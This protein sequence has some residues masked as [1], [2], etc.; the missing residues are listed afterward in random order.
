MIDFRLPN[1]DDID[2]SADS[3]LRVAGSNPLFT[4]GRIPGARVYRFRA[5]RTKKNQQNFG[6]AE[7]LN[8][9]EKTL[10]IEDVDLYI[11]KV[12]WKRGVLRVNEAGSEGYELSFHMDAGDI[13]QKLSGRLM[14]SLGLGSDPRDLLT[15]STYPTMNYVMFPVKNDVFYSENANYGGTVNAYASGAYLANDSTNKTKYSLTPFPYLLHILNKTFQ[16]LGYRGIAGAWTTDATIQRV[17]VF[18]NYAIDLLDGT[19]INVWQDTVTYNNH[20]P[21]MTVGKFLIEVALHF[22]IM[23]EVDDRE[24]MINIHR[25]KDV[26]ADQSYTDLSARTSKVYKVTPNDYHGYRFQSNIFSADELLSESMGWLAH[27]VDS[28]RQRIDS[29]AMP[30]LMD[31]GV[32][33]TNTPGSSPEFG[34]GTNQSGLRFMFFEGMVD[35]GAG[36]TKPKGNYEIAAQSLRWGGTTGIVEAF[37]QEFIDLQKITEEVKLQVRM[38]VPEFLNFDMKRKV[39]IDGVKYVVGEYQANVSRKTGLGDV[40]MK[41][42]KTLL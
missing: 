1:G 3:T 40:D 29:E 24:N 35:D 16:V 5:M 17:A 31:N 7:R 13:A 28:G 42:W 36:G 11:H 4:P 20:V 26:L 12:R 25:I 41:L 21:E 32:P 38:S 22:G 15:I 10:K 30:L 19:G 2:M 34:Q 18:S 33:Y 23:Y 8:L 9:Q 14:T 39:M 37:W 27:T 6:F